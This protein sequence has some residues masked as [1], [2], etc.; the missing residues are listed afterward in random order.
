M[1]IKK[2]LFLTIPVEVEINELSAADEFKFVSEQMQRADIKKNGF[3]PE[4]NRRWFIDY[5]RANCALQKALLESPQDLLRFAGTLA[6]QQLESSIFPGGGK[7]G[8]PLNSLTEALSP[9]IERLGLTKQFFPDDPYMLT[10]LE[11]TALD[12][13]EAVQVQLGAP[14]A[15]DGQGG[16]VT[17][18]PFA[19]ECTGAEPEVV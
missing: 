6:G 1:T 9:I 2:T 13:T 3:T 12:V 5:W 17:L 14:T 7:E 16:L 8:L 4:E 10:G 11:E 15:H 18:T 19:T